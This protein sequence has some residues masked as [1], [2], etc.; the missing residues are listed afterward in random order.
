MIRIGFDCLIL[1][2]QGE[3]AEDGGLDKDEANTILADDIERLRDLQQR[4]YADHRW[5]VLVVLQAMD[6][7]GKDGVIK[8]VMTG[9]NPQACVVH[10]FKAPNP[11][12]LDHDFLWRSVSRLPQ[13]GHI[14]IHNRS[15]YE[16]VL[17]VRVRPQYL[18]A[19]HIPES[20]VGKDIWEP[21]EYHYYFRVLE[22]ADEYFDYYRKRH[23]FWKMYG[24]DLPD[25]VLRKIYY[26]NAL[27]IIPGID[28]SMF[29]G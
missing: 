6:A 28:K 9:L 22:T 25:E 21:S 5:A 27:R 17:S 2:R 13:R 16:E 1:S 4:L 11:D 12:E 10:P 18:K 26:Q 24:L 19:Q 8:H 23:A 20:L 15:H 7:G 3:P 14:G 29:P